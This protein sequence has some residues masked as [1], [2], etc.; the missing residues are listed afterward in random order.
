MEDDRL[1]EAEQLLARVRIYAHKKPFEEVVQMRKEIR[2][3]IDLYF[4]KYYPDASF[5][6]KPR[7]VD[8]G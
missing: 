2:D 5:K 1:N 7:V 6:I 3:D 8:C 4:K